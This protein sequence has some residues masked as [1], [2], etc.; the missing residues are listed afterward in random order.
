MPQLYTAEEYANMHLIYGECHGNG[1]AAARLFRE[2]YPNLERYPDH[3]VFFNVHQAYMEG[4]L[5]STRRSGERPEAEDDY[6][7][8]VLGEIANDPSTSVRGIELATGVPKSTAH[9]IL[10]KLKFHPYHVQR[11]QT[12]LEDV[13]LNIYRE[14]WLQQDGCPAHYARP[15]HDY[16]NTEYPGRWIG[17]LGPI[18][19]PPR[20]PDLNPLDFFYWGFIKSKVYAKPIENLAELRNKIVEAAED[21]NLRRY[22]R[23]IKRSF[24]RRCRA[25]I[26]AEGKQFEHLL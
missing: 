21:F 20:S 6:E 2:R 1:S 17:R 26:Y 18:L 10:K 14:M 3:R 5:P 13:P 25:C 4:R 12:L 8:V 24:L 22:G 19:W 7:D 15:V 23:L 11:V 16:L 9:R